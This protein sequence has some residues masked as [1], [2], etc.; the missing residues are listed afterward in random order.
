MAAASWIADWANTSNN[1]Q[2]RNFYEG[3]MTPWQDSDFDNPPL[4]DEP[5]NWKWLPRMTSTPLLPSPHR[6]DVITTITSMHNPLDPTTPQEM[7][8]IDNPEPRVLF[9]YEQIVGGLDR[10]EIE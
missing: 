7:R 3:Y 10:D 5:E 4:A 1:V 6:D 9:S 8:V 2:L